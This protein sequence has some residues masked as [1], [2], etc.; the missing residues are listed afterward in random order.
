MIWTKEY[1]EILNNRCH[2]SATVVNT[3]VARHEIDR[4]EPVVLTQLHTLGIEDPVIPA[5]RGKTDKTRTRVGLGPFHPHV[6]V[7]EEPVPG[8]D[9]VVQAVQVKVPWIPREP[10]SVPAL[11]EEERRSIMA[12]DDIGLRPCTD[13][14]GDVLSVPLFL[15]PPASA[16]DPG[17]PVD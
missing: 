3:W 13:N 8:L 12:D 7:G 14:L 11:L 6:V 9:A 15:F 2:I 4:S 10:S 17:R 5:P 16:K 1:I